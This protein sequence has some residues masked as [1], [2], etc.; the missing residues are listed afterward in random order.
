MMSVFINTYE[1]RCYVWFRFEISLL[2]LRLLL[3]EYVFIAGG[4]IFYSKYNPDSR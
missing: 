4:D 1:D 2:I 3:P